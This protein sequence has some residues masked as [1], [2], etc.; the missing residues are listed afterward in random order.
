MIFNNVEVRSSS[1]VSSAFGEG[2]VILS[3]VEVGVSISVR[4]TDGM[5]S[6]VVIGLN[7]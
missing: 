7:S 2:S 5:Y 4:W 6:F 1:V 3:R